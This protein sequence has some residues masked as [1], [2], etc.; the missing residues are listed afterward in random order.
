MNLIAAQ[1]LERVI[2]AAVIG[3]CFG[4][5][6]V[7]RHLWTRLSERT[8]HVVGRIVL[9]MILLGVIIFAVV[10]WRTNL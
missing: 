1:L 10:M 3:L 5:A 6:G 2:M 4:V 9:A 7:L 8:K